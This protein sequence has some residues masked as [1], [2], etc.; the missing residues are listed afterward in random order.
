VG[1]SLIGLRLL[2]VELESEEQLAIDLVLR[3]N[4]KVLARKHVAKFKAGH[5][6]VNLAVGD[7]VKRGKASLSI[8]L[9]DA[10]GNELALVRRVRLPAA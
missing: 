3:R 9:D 7:K 10:A 6:V 8:E 2:R 1:R 5:R 4:G